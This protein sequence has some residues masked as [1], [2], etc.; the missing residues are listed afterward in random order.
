MLLLPEK[1]A[2]DNSITYKVPFT[3][4]FTAKSKASITISEEFD[5]DFE[6]E[7]VDVHQNKEIVFFYKPEKTLIEAD[8][9]FDLPATEQYSW[10]RGP[11]NK[12]FLTN[13]FV[14]INSTAGTAI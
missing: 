7:Y 9:V 4:V 10:T 5:R 6:Y 1:R 13:L 12:G 2:A 14:G 3:T 11:A 8:Y